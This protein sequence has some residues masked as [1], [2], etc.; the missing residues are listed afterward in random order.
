MNDVRISEE[1][2]GIQNGHDIE[3]ETTRKLAGRA[4]QH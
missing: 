3:N 1:I 2:N 4:R